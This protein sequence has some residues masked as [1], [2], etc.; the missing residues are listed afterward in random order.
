MATAAP[1]AAAGLADRRVIAILLAGAAVAVLGVIEEFSPMP[2][3][4]RLT[5]QSLAAGGVVL[6]GVQVT[7]TGDWPD[8]PVT[9]MCT[10]ALTNAFSMLDRRNRALGTVSAVTAAFLAVTA[11]VLAEPVQV[12]PSTALACACLGFLGQ[13]RLGGP[14]SLFAGFVLTCEATVLTSGRDTGT[15]AAG[16][17]LPAFVALVGAGS[18][19]TRPRW[20]LGLSRAMTAPALC[21]I[22]AAA[23]TAWLATAAGLVPPMFAVAGTAV[24]TAVLLI[25]PR[26]AGGR[27]MAV[28]AVIP[29]VGAR[30]G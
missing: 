19:I 11:L 14:A 4:A 7:L 15:I 18:H 28:T 26:R 16:L 5:V 17:I 22:C 2:A 8:G 6:S 23:G 24:T 13:S 25:P 12:L 29:P 3:L 21:G 20:R 27:P 30:R 9:V 1:V 10:V